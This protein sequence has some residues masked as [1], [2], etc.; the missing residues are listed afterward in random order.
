MRDFQ[1]NPPAMTQQPSGAAGGK[2]NGAANNGALLSTLVE[3]WPYI[4]PSDRRDLKVRVLLATGLLFLAKL[5]TMAVP[6]TFKW[7]TDA[8]AAHGMCRRTRAW[9]AWAIAAPVVLTL[10]YGGIRILMALLTQLRDGLFAK[11]AMHAVRRLAYPHL[12][13]HAPSC[14]CASISSARPAV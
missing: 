11:V 13:A 9:M 2:D 7:A 10:A 1:A 5:A 6:F 3:L 14:R 8:L 12:R 4:W